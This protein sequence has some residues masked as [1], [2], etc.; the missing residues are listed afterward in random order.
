VAAFWTPLGNIRLNS[1]YFNPANSSRN[2]ELLALLYHEVIHLEQGPLVALSVRGELE[3]WQRQFLLLKKL[4]R[5]PGH[6][7]IL[8]LLA[9]PLNWDRSVLR[10]ARELMQEYAGKGYLA[11][12]LPL[13]PIPREVRYWIGSLPGLTNHSKEE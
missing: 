13:Y 4:G 9:L 5:A 6:R 10:R 2:P 1:R 7:A 11:H 12:L 3:A 8:G